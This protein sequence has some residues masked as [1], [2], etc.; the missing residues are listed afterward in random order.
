MGGD[1]S[2][3]PNESNKLDRAASNWD[4]LYSGKGLLGTMFDW[5]DEGTKGEALKHQ[6][7]LSPTAGLIGG[8]LDYFQKGDYMDQM[9][10]DANKRFNFMNNESKKNWAMKMN[11]YRQFQNRMARD[12]ANIESVN[13]GQGYLA[14]DNAAKYQQGGTML[15]WRGNT[16]SDPFTQDASGNV[17][18]GTNNIANSAFATPTNPVQSLPNKVTT[19]P[20]KTAGMSTVKKR[21][22]GDRARENEQDRVKKLTV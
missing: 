3:A 2:Y 19:A 14:G 21:M 16:K 10:E 4:S 15:D 13:S 20:Q 17:T 5:T 7:W 22:P 1:L 12:R 9:K 6:G 11:E 18:T 8:V